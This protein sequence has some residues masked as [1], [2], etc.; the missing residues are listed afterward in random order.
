MYETHGKREMY[1]SFLE[2]SSIEKREILDVQTHSMLLIL[3]F[4]LIFGGGIG[5]G[6][7]N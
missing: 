6:M 1:G 7:Q 3:C 4:F 2:L 5:H